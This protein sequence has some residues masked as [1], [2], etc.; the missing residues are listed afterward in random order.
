MAA[1]W[2]LLA[3]MGI[4]LTELFGRRVVS[5]SGALTAA[6]VVQAVAAMSALASVAVVSSSLSWN[7]LVLGALSGVGLA[8]GTGCYFGGVTRSTA[9][10]VSPL[11]ATLAAVIPFAYALARGSAIS[12]LA[13]GG[14][15]LA[16]IGLTL[17]ASGGSEVSAVAVGIRWGAAS[18]LGYGLGLSVLLESAADN[19]AWPAVW[20]RLAAAIVLA[21]GAA[22][23][24]RRFLPARGARISGMIAGAFSGAAS[25]MYL[26]GIAIDPPPAVVATSMF[27][28]FSVIIGFFFFADDVSRKQV[29]GIAL[30]LLGVAGVVV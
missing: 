23:T 9:T 29:L 20:Q 13:I 3:A 16:F 7:G 26:L 22:A 30:V 5:I 8:I 11:A 4:G 27:P 1:I 24:G 10:V 6:F 19:G 17:I 25:V 18:G 15:I 28:A 12:L 21:V 14:A 2:G